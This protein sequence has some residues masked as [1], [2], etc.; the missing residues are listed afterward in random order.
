[1]LQMILPAGV[2]SQECFGEPPGGVLF[3]EEQQII[4][5]AVPCSDWPVR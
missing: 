2:E 3:P 1:M 4:A 5:Y